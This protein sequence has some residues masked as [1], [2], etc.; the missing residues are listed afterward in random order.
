MRKFL[1]SLTLIMTIFIMSGCSKYFSIGEEQTYCEEYG[2]DYTDVGLCANPLEI[3]K[4]KN[5]LET[6]RNRSARRK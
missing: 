3:L 4:H 5:E 2:C 6:L 1:V